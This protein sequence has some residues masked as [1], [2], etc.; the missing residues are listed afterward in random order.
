MPPIAHPRPLSPDEKDRR[1]AVAGRGLVF[2]TSDAQ[3]Q[4]Y[5]AWGILEHW[6]PNGLPEINI[7]TPGGS[8]HAARFYRT[9]GIVLMR[10]CTEKECERNIVE[11]FEKDVGAQP[12]ANKGLL[13]ESSAFGKMVKEIGLYETLTCKRNTPQNRKVHKNMHDHWTMH[14]HFGA[15]SDP[16]V[17]HLPG[18]WA[19]RQK[20]SLVR[21]AKL[22]TGL[23]KVMVDINRCIQKIPGEG[24]NEFLH[25][26]TDV[27]KRMNDSERDQ[28]KSMQGKAMFSDSQFVG[29][30]GSHT[31]EFF[32]KFKDTYPVTYAAEWKKTAII[33]K[34][35]VAVTPKNG[36][37]G[38]ADVRHLKM[39][40]KIPAGCMIA[41]S[42]RLM[43]G[44]SKAPNDG[45]VE[46]GM[47]LGYM[48]PNGRP[49]YRDKV[50]TDSFNALKKTFVARPKDRSRCRAI[51]EM[52]PEQS[53]R[54]MK[55]EDFWFFVP[56]KTQ[57]S[58]LNGS[59]DDIIRAGDV[60]E[61]GR[62]N[63]AI[64]KASIPD[65]HAV[66]VAG[67]ISRWA[68]GERTRVANVHAKIRDMLKD[69][70]TG[71]ENEAM[72]MDEVLDEKQDRIRSLALG[73]APVLWPSYD[74]IEYFPYHFRSQCDALTKRL[75]NMSLKFLS[76]CLWF[77][78]TPSSGNWM[79]NPVPVRLT[80]YNRPELS[81]LGWEIF[82]ATEAE[83]RGYVQSV[84]RLS[85]PGLPPGLGG[86]A[87]GGGK[88]KKQRTDFKMCKCCNGIV[89]L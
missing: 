88:A 47:Y 29:V 89:L 64:T 58:E 10:V 86:G 24:D 74:R 67:D 50:E 15:N 46:W 79:P 33:P 55:P 17:F 27:G 45:A 1:N 87:G 5:N 31:P 25:W 78:W 23:D 80:P 70:D 2:Q 39:T 65:A 43:H 6:F 36:E 22:I 38:D 59:K 14:R 63:A 18:V 76:K 37:G 82:G 72:G 84:V 44:H 53:F 30:P 68:A 62:I 54:S 57:L 8:E 3:A 9:H 83:V 34:W 56:D 48:D 20:E 32:V 4:C 21:A 41:W 28:F 77:K 7:D 40:F 85:N 51:L 35:D 49:A 19:I 69:G 73:I 52:L 81:A 42:D 60:A 13:S 71:Y 16:D 11:Q 66:G 26:D 12:W 75:L 61:G